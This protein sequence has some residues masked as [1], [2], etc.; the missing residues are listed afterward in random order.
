MRNYTNEAGYNANHVEF[1]GNVRLARPM[2]NIRWTGKKNIFAA[3]KGL[4]HETESRTVSPL[5][6]E[7]R[8][9]KKFCLHR[10]ALLQAGMQI[11]PLLSIQRSCF[12]FQKKAAHDNRL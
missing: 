11:P 9:F 4:Y 5:L 8:S 6:R 12:L 10:K 3:W 7:M 1:K 2:H